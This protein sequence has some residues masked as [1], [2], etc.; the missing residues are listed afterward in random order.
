MK[1]E[2]QDQRRHK[3]QTVLADS[4]TDF[5]SYLDTL[6]AEV[7]ETDEE[8]SSPA[9]KVDNF[10][11]DTRIKAQPV[12]DEDS[13]L[14]T[15][16]NPDI[17]SAAN[18]ELNATN[19]IPKW[20]DTPFQ[21]LMFGVCGL[22]LGVPLVSLVGILDFNKTLCRLPGQSRWQLGVLTHRQ[23]KVMVIDTARLIM[24]ERIGTIQ[25]T[26]RISGR[27]LLLIGEGDIGLL[28]DAINTTVKIDNR[29][30]RW[31][32]G[33]G[34]QPWLAGILIEQLSVLLDLDGLLEMIQE[35]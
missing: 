22:T 27:Y 28:V 32:R 26:H 16:L 12:L 29:Q 1:S 3:Q 2:E 8:V 11:A 31:R 23:Q 35:T 7:D 4:N 13:G 20:A 24:P 10:G 30:V 25:G 33:S 21:V 6:L 18:P 34:W 9:V 14:V 15:A 17:G 19:R 5:I